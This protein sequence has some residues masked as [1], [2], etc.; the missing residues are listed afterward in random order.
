MAI[1]EMQRAAAVAE[2]ARVAYHRD[3]RARFAAENPTVTG[4]AIDAG[5]SAEWKQLAA[6]PKAA[7]QRLVFGS[8]STK[9]AK[10]AKPGKPA[11]L[12]C[13]LTSCKH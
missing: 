4:K 12:I 13:E 8:L 10:P 9:P 6:K 11:R 2:C 1:A 7:K 5:L 3:Q